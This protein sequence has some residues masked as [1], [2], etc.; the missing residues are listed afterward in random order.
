MQKSRIFVLVVLAAAAFSYT[1]EARTIVQ[2]HSSR[3]KVLGACGSAGGEY[4]EF[5]DATGGYGCT[6]KCKGGKCE[7]ACDKDG[8]CHGSTPGLQAP[9]ATL[10]GV[11][12]G[13]QA[14]QSP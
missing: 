13:G 1:A 7:V 12:T 5:S 9:P 4:N 14:T 2:F 11:L 6:T 3:M 8:N 10:H